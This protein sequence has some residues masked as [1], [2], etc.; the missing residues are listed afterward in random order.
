MEPLLSRPDEVR[1][2]HVDDDPA[3]ADLT[4]DYLAQEAGDLTV[5]SETDP[6]AV[7]DRV[8]AEQFDC[9]VSD[10]DM[11]EV[12]GL[13]LLAAI[14][15]EYPTLPYVL[16]TGKGSEE[17]AAEAI[18]AG[19]DSYLRKQSSTSQFIVL[20]NRIQALVDRYWERRRVEKAR[21]VYELLAQVAT[22]AF[23]IRDMETNVT[24]YSEGIRQFGY[25]PGIREDGFEWWVE[26]V[27][28]DDREAS[29]S[30]NAA[31]AAAEPTGFEDIDDEHG[32]FTHRYRWRC[33]DGSYIDCLSRGVVRFEDGE[34]VEMVGAM[35]DVGDR[36]PDNGDG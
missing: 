2:L 5:V 3:F 12:D 27:H 19:V 15:E 34:G 22:D 8:A 23:W 28:P 14:R 10:F 29:R 32:R 21:E 16:F 9:I 4:A 33:A 18:E 1:V 26:R 13:D 7:L 11:P 24:Q 25:E 17:I 35:T 20:A 30:E 6:T 36:D 31:Q